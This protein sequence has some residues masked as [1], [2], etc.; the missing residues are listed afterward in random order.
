MGFGGRRQ[1]A[2][3]ALAVLT[4][5]DVIKYIKL[6]KIPVPQK[7]G[8]GSYSPAAW[9]WDLA[10]YAL[11]GECTGRL[12]YVKPSVYPVLAAYIAGEPIMYQG[13]LYKGDSLGFCN[14]PSQYSLPPIEPVKTKEIRWKRVYI[15]GDFGWF[16]QTEPQPVVAG[17]RND[18]NYLGTLVVRYYYEDGALVEQATQ[19]LPKF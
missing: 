9:Y 1:A 8:N 5:E 12:S 16:E 6:R 13:E 10:Q 11:T 2:Q 17:T 19:F 3:P 18:P 7:I 4:L 14:P 15:A